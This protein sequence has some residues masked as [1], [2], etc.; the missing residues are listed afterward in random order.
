MKFSKNTTLGNSSSGGTV[1]KCYGTHMCTAVTSCGADRDTAA[2]NAENYE[3][4]KAAYTPSN[5]SPNS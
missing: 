1:S 2:I 3:A 4:V 5:P